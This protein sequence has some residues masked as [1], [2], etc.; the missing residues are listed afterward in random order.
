MTGGFKSPFLTFKLAL[1]RLKETRIDRRVYRFYERLRKVD[2][3]VLFYVRGNQSVRIKALVNRAHEEE[4]ETDSFSTQYGVKE[5]VFLTSEL[6]LG[7]N[8]IIPQEGDKILLDGNAYFITPGPNGAYFDNT[9]AGGVL[10][11]VKGVLH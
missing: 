6:K 2:G 9:E 5:F 4:T 8:L 1:K 3:R 10:T 7:N 11:K